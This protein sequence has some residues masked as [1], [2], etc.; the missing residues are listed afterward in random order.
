MLKE[1]S[2]NLENSFK[3][4]RKSIAGIL[5]VSCI[6][7]KFVFLTWIGR[8]SLSREFPAIGWTT[9]RISLGRYFALGKISPPWLFAI[10]TSHK[11]KRILKIKINLNPQQLSKNTKS[12]KQWTHGRILRQS[13]RSRS[14]TWHFI[15][16]NL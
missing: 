13:G 11:W 2:T 3:N 9:Q 14:R 8:V 6:Y 4:G 12:L 7:L 5:A 1:Y 10:N 15:I 16:F